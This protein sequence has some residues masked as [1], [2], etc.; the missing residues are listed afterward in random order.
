MNLENAQIAVL[1]ESQYQELELWYPVMRL[2]EEGANVLVVAP[3]ADQV[4]SSKLGYPVKPDLAVADVGAA[5]FDGVVIPGGFA[6]EGMRK[7]KPMVDLVRDI[8]AQGNLVAAICHAGWMLASS[9]IAR[10]RRLTCVP[11]IKDDVINAGADYVEEPV[12]KDGNLITSRL[13][14]DLPD[15]CREIVKYLREVPPRRNS[16]RSLQSK[17]GYPT[18]AQYT[19][20]VKVI[21]G[22][23]GKASANYTAVVVQDEPGR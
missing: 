10:G 3:S 9:G 7:H 17:Q 5:D 19:R 22:T 16:A 21:M 2:R 8:H 15:F 6:P 20:P 18:S 1:A 14:G 13:P 12:V 4:Y 11:N 23:R